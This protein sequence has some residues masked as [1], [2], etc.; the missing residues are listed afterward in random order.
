MINGFRLE[1]SPQEDD[2]ILLHNRVTLSELDL[3]I[4]DTFHQDED[5]V[6]CSEAKMSLISLSLSFYTAA[7]TKKVLLMVCRLWHPWLPPV[8]VE[9]DGGCKEKLF[10]V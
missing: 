4:K 6:H 7:N 2:K 1:A 5:V 10:L 3:F 8:Q 9:I